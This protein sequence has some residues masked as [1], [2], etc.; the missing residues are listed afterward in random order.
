MH[1][2]E[3]RKPFCDLHKAFVALPA[4]RGM[5]IVDK[6]IIII[7]DSDSIQKKKKVECVFSVCTNVSCQRGTREGRS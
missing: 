7:D 2:S 3:G 5:K 1:P 6:H 4:C